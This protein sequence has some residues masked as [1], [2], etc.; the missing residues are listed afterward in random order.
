[1]NMAAGKLRL[2]AAFI[3][4]WF[5]APGSTL[6]VESI[7]TTDVSTVCVTTSIAKLVQIFAAYGHHHI[8]VLDTQEKLAGMITQADLILA[9][10][11]QTHA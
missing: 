3:E 9:L 11:R 6:T 10:Y 2:L 8:P 5:A 4:R 7:M 1:R